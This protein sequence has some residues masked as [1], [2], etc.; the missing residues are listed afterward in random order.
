MTE[1]S[2]VPGVVVRTDEHDY[3]PLHPG[4]L[5]GRLRT[6]ALHL[7][8]PRVSEAHALLSLRGRSLWLFGLRGGLRVG[9]TWRHEVELEEGLVLGLADDVDLEVV[10]VTLPSTVHALRD[11]QGTVTALDRPEWSVMADGTVVPGFLREGVAWVWSSAGAWR[12]QV[13]GGDSGALAADETFVAA[14]RRFTLESEPVAVADVVATVTSG[15]NV[16]PFTIDTWEQHTKIVVEGRAEVELT[17]NG[18]RILRQAARK[19]EQGGAVHW[20]EVAE[21]IWRV[22][23]TEQNWFT[24]HRRLQHRLRTLRLP[25]DLV[26]C[27]G[28][29]VRLVMRA[30]IDDLTI[31]DRHL[32]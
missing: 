29:Q 26:S 17:G 10:S 16:P 3:V 2:S 12:L 20:S 9:R 27:T 23:A 11:D 30:G 28:G 22:N 4:D 32:P 6:A 24:N 15:W 31:H 21:A 19:T 25:P 5:I 8:D 1:T 7:D 14:N 18:H 13:V